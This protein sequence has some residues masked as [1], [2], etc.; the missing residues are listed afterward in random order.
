MEAHSPSLFHGETLS[1]ASHQGIEHNISSQHPANSNT[2][3]MQL[4]L[5]LLLELLLRFK[6]KKI[7]CYKILFK[8]FD[9]LTLNFLLKL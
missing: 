9:L 3:I 5:V 2:P 8:H 4:C 7:I 6:K 1:T